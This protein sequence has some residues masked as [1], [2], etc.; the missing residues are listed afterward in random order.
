MTKEYTP[1]QLSDMKERFSQVQLACC[2]GSRQ[3]KDNEV[4]FGGVGIS[5]LTVAIAKLLYTPNVTLMTEAGYVGF[6]GISSMGSPA[7]NVGAVGATLH[8]G[9]FD[10]FRDMQAGLVQAACLGLAQV[11]KFGNANVTYVNPNVRMNGSG[12]GGDISCSAGRV[13]YVV[14]YAGRLFQERVDYLTNPGF[15]D[16]S[17]DA[18]QK[19]GLVGGGPACIVSDRGIFRFDETTHEMYLAEVFPWQDEEDIQEI[20]SDFPWDLKIADD[21]KIIDPPSDEEMGAI[22]LMDPG[23]GYLEESIL[24]RPV[25]KIMLSGRND[26]NAYR[27]VAE[28]FRKKMEEAKE[29]LM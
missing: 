25:T 12:G 13:V 21:L 20:R 11:D 19:A 2:A 28:I 4:I 14:K 22:E 26:I 18:R 17:P 23:R 10:M 7:D 5:F 24:N 15:L 6:T 3:F 29:R 8:Q 16:G 27:D 9:L 1:E